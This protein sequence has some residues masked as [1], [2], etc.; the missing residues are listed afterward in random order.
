MLTL[1]TITHKTHT[2]HKRS[3][4]HLAS[5]HLCL[6]LFSASPLRLF[7]SCS[8]KS[9]HHERTAGRH[10]QPHPLCL[11][12][13]RGVRP[14]RKVP[15]QDSPAAP[16]PRPLPPLPSRNAARV[17]ALHSLS[18]LCCRCFAAFLFRSGALAAHTSGIAPHAAL[19]ARSSP[20]RSLLPRPASQNGRHALCAAPRPH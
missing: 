11:W 8:Q 12:R 13:P 20:L 6:R 14:K 10:S 7:P 19:A 2:H 4:T 15:P 5:A 9:R 16:S 17:T 3:G 18:L 1:S